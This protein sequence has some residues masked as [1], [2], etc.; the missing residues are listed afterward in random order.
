[1]HIGIFIYTVSR[2]GTISGKETYEAF[3]S[4][5]NDDGVTDHDQ[6]TTQHHDVRRQPTCEGLQKRGEVQSEGHVP[7]ASVRTV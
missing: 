4:E 3:D 6:M 7:S 1:M 2:S 5:V